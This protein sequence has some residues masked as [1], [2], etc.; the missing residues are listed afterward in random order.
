MAKASTPK[1]PDNNKEYQRLEVEEQTVAAYLKAEGV[2]DLGG[3]TPIEALI[4]RTKS[5]AEGDAALKVQVVEL[6][7]AKAALDTSTAKLVN[8]LQTAGIEIPEGADLDQL[9]I[10]TIA[11]GTDG[12]SPGELAAIARADAAEKELAEVKGEFAELTV[13]ADALVNEKN[14]LA[15]ELAALKEGRGHAPEA[16]EP[17]PEPEVAPRVRPEAARDLG[18]HLCRL[19]MSDLSELIGNGEGFEIAFG[20]GEYELVELN[21]QPLG[22]ADLMAV[23]GKRI[24]NV[25]ILVRGGT[26]RE[27]IHGAALL[28]GGEQV[29]YCEFPTPIAIEPG[30]DRQFVKA[31][32]F[33]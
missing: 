4:V 15:N 8:G 7:K 23:E 14:R 30:Q 19:D 24:V 22:G 3:R 17:E 29:H 25:P 18:P 21:P 1:G 10:D 2:E 6:E 9:I 16:E 20:N 12:V 27:E 11:K 5:L 13:D 28:H 31:I 26:V 32:I 33:G